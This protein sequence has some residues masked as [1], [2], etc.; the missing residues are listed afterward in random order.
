MQQSL[1]SVKRVDVT[2][3]SDSEDEQPGMKTAAA[4][5]GDGD[6]VGEGK[7]GK[8]QTVVSPV[9]TQLVYHILL[10]S[11]NFSFCKIV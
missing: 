11:A 2:L 4:G 8:R 6:G 5:A 1:A 10:L 3:S 9:K 7:S